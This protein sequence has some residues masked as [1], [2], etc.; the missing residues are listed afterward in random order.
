M[1]YIFLGMLLVSNVLAENALMCDL[2][3]KD[4]GIIE[5]GNTVSHTFIIK[6][7]SEKTIYADKVVSSC[8]CIVTS[9]KD[10]A[11]D[12]NQSTDIKI[13]YNSFGAGGTEISKTVEIYAKDSNYSPLILTL[14]ANIKGIPPEKR[15]VI[16]PA[17]IT[18]NGEQNR[19]HSLILQ[20]PSDPNIKFSIIVP[21]WLNYSLQK[22]KYNNIAGVVNWDIEIF[23]KNRK[24]ERLNGDM[25]VNSN[26]PHFERVTMTIKIEPTPRLV[27]NPYM[28]VFDVNVQNQSKKV[29]IRP[30]DSTLGPMKNFLK[31]KPSKDCI[32]TSWTEDNNGIYLVVLNKT[33]SPES[34][35]IEIRGGDELLGTIPVIFK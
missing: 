10:F 27:I 28:I 25:V 15:I 12:P 7:T 9:K 33:C 17:G 4:L 34:G 11:L 35:K 20:V 1:K 8:G 6:N 3:I 24:Y 13:E 21:E 29:L 19:K 30:V 2:P 18:L 26:L 23:L 16:T 31:I 32:E 14:K 22:S 5:E